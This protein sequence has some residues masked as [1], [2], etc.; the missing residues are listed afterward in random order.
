MNV[1]ILDWIIIA[2]YVVGLLSI[3]F[4]LSG[5]QHN[6]EG[7]FAGNRSVPSW[8][9][10]LSVV[11]T[12]LSAGT[13]LGVPQLS[14]AKDLTF[15]WL[16]LG[17]VLGG[18]IAALALVPPLYNANTITIYGYLEQRFGPRAVIASSL[19]FLL[20]QSLSAGARFFVAA[21]A[22]SLLLFG[23]TDPSSLQLTIMVLGVIGTVYTVFGGIQAVIWT[24]VV[25]LIIMA[26]AGI[27]CIFLLL[28]V[29]PASPSEW[30][31]TLQANDK[32]RVIN[33]EFDFT[34]PFTLW[35]AFFAYAVFNVA[36]Y[37]CDQ[38]MMQRLLTCKSPRAAISS[39]IYSRLVSLPIILIFAT[40]GLLLYLFYTHPEALG[41]TTLVEPLEDSKQVLPQYI[42]N[43][44][45]TGF[46]GII[47]A[48]LL[49]AAMSSFDS[50]ANAM[51]STLVSD[52]LV[53]IRSFRH[54][55]LLKSSRWAVLAMGILLTLFAML[56]TV[57]QEAGGQRLIDFALGIMV[58]SYA[59]LLGVFLTALYTTRGNETSVIAA[60]IAGAVIV[61]ALQPYVLP[62]WSAP[63]LGEPLVLAWPWW[64]L[65]AGSTSL[66]VCMLGKS[67][68]VAR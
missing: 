23:D 24:D 1:T 20:G 11:A 50:S 16:S 5:K 8:A 42:I 3:G 57:M 9:V 28:E 55:S 43:H 46:I 54:V 31:A 10:T 51:A 39:L 60:L 33:L 64:M 52:L 6:L 13:F 29:I 32:L 48:G 61:L 38:D 17:S 7:F 44:L 34:D 25:Q 67:K 22:I 21:I 40:I 37:G 36:Q 27:F 47:M 15:L 59:G 45:P 4:F 41:I 12:S 65:V 66:I 68:V 58:F 26:G 2:V 19:F 18:I 62:H 56:A 14:F 49:A 35:A 30:I 53:R 63:L